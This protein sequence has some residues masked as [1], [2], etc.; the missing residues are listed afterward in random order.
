MKIYVAAHCRW[1]AHY[2]ALVLSYSGHEITSGW[3]YTDFKPTDQHDE[4]E[5]AGIAQ[6]DFDDVARSDALVLVAGP[7]RYPGGKFV[8][9]GIALGMGKHVVVIGRRENMLIWLPSIR[10][11]NDPHQAATLLKE[12]AA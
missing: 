11:V 2:V 4:T 10:Q 9:T 1:A 12:L 5:R 6:D 8:E 3:I 7:D